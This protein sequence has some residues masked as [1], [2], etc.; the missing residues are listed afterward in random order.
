MLSFL[1]SF[2]FYF[3]FLLFSPFLLLFPV[4]MC[5]MPP[6]SRPMLL[7]II[8]NVAV[9][10]AAKWSSANNPLAV[11]EA[12]GELSSPEPPDLTWN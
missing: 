8:I 7:A 3:I 2:Y 6:G 12:R 5:R 9:G 4:L 1:A 11:A 10:M